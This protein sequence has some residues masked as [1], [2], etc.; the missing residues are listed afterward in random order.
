MAVV[1]DQQNEGDVAYV[2]MGPTFDGV[3]FMAA[4]DLIF[5]GVEQ[6]SGYTEQI[7]HA[8]RLALK[9]RGEKIH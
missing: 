1:V 3:A 2:P 5:E 8:R 9:R 6:P 7:L 4:R